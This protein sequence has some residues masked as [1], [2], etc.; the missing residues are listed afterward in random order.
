MI[1]CD[2]WNSEFYNN[3]ETVLIRHIWQTSV[4]MRPTPSAEE[5]CVILS[6]A[7]RQRL[8]RPWDDEIT[9]S[10]DVTKAQETHTFNLNIFELQLE[11][12]NLHPLWTLQ[13]FWSSDG[14]HFYK[15]LMLKPRAQ[16]EL[17]SSPQPL[18]CCVCPQAVWHI[19]SY[20][21]KK[22]ILCEYVYS[23]D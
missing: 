22:I 23:T 5:G 20:E 3:K 9:L 21:R 10:A 13:M 8:K 16:F 1:A 18:R 11:V 4:T 2:N 7:P 19:H 12:Q 14:W 6:K 17:L 15:H